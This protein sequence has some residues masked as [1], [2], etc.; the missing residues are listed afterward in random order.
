VQH[1]VVQS[2]IR[3]TKR[4]P[5]LGVLLPLR[6]P[7][8]HKRE[9]SERL[10]EFDRIRLVVQGPFNLRDSRSNGDSFDIYTYGPSIRLKDNP[11]RLNG[12]DNLDLWITSVKRHNHHPSAFPFLSPS[13]QEQHPGF[14]ALPPRFSFRPGFAPP[15]Q[16]A[17]FRP[18]H[19]TQPPYSI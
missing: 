12:S 8:D 6:A 13:E 7:C 10:F 1:P 2:R 4:P 5:R 15:P 16:L 9:T 11:L 19:P 14:C 18:S 17:R 3:L